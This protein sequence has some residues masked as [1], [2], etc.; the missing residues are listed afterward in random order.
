MAMGLTPSR[1]EMCMKEST[2]MASPGAKEST[3]GG[4][5]RHMKVT[6][7]RGRNMVK[8]T[9]SKVKNQISLPTKE[10]T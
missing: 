9:G 6:S 4:T 2:D 8:D 3:F 7:R 5:V 10:L 1:M